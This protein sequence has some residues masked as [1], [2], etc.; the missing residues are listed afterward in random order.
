LAVDF[1]LAQESFHIRRESEI[2][3]LQYY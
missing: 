1:E 2:E 3:G